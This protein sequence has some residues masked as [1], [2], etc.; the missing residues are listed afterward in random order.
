MVTESQGLYK[1]FTFYQVVGDIENNVKAFIAKRKDL[2][3]GIIFA[4]DQLFA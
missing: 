2:E 1:M 4:L 3:S